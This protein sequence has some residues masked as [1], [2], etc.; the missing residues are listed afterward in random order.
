MGTD[1]PSL[2]ELIRDRDAVGGSWLWEV[3]PML[4]G[5]ALLQRQ[6]EELD[7]LRGVRAE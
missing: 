3:A 6:I 5:T 4:P 1:Q 7:R 2:Q